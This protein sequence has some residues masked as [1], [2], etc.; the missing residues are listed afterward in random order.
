MILMETEIWS[1]GLVIAGWFS[2]VCDLSRVLVTSH[3]GCDSPLVCEKNSSIVYRVVE[4]VKFP[5]C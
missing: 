5:F 1:S 2:L 4:E 3:D